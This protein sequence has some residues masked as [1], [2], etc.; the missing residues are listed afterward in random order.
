[1]T[2]RARTGGGGESF[3]GGSPSAP[4]IRAGGV[5]TAVAEAAA[6]TAAEEAAKK[7]GAERTADEAPPSA[8][9][10]GRSGVQPAIGA[11]TGEVSTPQMQGASMP[12]RLGSPQE[13]S[14]TTPPT[15]KREDPVD[16]SAAARRGGGGVSEAAAMTPDP[17][18]VSGG[19]GRTVLGR[20]GLTLSSHNEVFPSRVMLSPGTDSD[21]GSSPSPEVL[22]RRSSRPFSGGDAGREGFAPPPQG[23]CFSHMFPRSSTST[24]AC[25]FLLV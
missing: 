4:V 22:V 1:M 2:P 8:A 9:A 21:P 13:L 15:T 25:L 6:E 19:D 12:G 20:L 16:D 24:L 23:L 11:A 7:R 10:T 14:P 3:S 5:V 18:E 17:A